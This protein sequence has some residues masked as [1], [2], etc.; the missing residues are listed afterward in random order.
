MTKKLTIDS[1][2]ETNPPLLYRISISSLKGHFQQER[3]R[4][5]SFLPCLKIKR[6]KFHP[7]KPTQSHDLRNPSNLIVGI[8]VV[9]SNRSS[10]IPDLIIKISLIYQSYSAQTKRAR[11]SS[12]VSI[13]IS[14]LLL[15][16]YKSPFLAS[17]QS[18][19]LRGNMY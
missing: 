14:H 9:S 6:F 5:I 10:K 16:P 2:I 15:W 19:K 13:H 7:E 8:H 17:P 4:I 3:L 18:I 11:I 12:R 1:C